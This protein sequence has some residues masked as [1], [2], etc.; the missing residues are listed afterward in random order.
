MMGSP[1]KF[2]ACCRCLK[3]DGNV[4]T[5]VHLEFEGPSDFNGWGCVQCGVPQRGALAVIC[6]ACADGMK[7]IDE[8]SFICGGK[9]M[10]DR[11]RLPLEGYERKPFGHDLS[12][13]P[14]VQQ[15]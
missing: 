5:I 14:E 8:L 11:E 4:R 1:S 9:Y 3:D 12:K 2:G 10:V 6:D 13:H 7:S 15:Q